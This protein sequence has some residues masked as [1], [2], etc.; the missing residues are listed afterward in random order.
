MRLKELR[1]A[2]KESQQKLA[3]LLNVSQ[4][5]VSRYELGQA[6]PDYDTLIILAKHYNVSIDYLIG[7]TDSKLPYSKSDLSDSEQSLL[8]LF[9]QLNDTQK[10]KVIAYMQGLNDNK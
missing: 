5:M 7:Y 9:K 6:Y 8:S 2:K 3:F 4:T 1:E 10:E